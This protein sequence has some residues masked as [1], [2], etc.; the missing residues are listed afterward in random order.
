MTQVDLGLDWQFQPNWTLSA[1][2]RVLVAS[3]IG[4]AD[5]QIPPYIVDIP[6]IADIDHNGQLVLHGVFA[7]LEWNY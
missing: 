7:G 5:H 6:E 4:L 3:G 1:G 2:Y